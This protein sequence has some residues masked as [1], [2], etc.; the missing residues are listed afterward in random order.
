MTVAVHIVTIPFIQVLILRMDLDML[1]LIYKPD[2][3]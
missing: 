2:S 1:F 3:L